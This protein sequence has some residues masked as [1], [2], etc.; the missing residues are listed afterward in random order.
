MSALDDFDRVLT[1]ASV[2]LFAGAMLDVIKEDLASQ[3][4]DEDVSAATE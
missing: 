3:L 2:R 4:A 1:E